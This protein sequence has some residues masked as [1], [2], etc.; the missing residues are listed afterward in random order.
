MQNVPVI[1][2]DYIAK[3]I[4]DALF[5]DAM[6]P[7]GLVAGSGNVKSD[8][9]PIDGYLMSTT[10]TINAMDRNGRLYEITVREV[11]R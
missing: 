6:S 1:Y 10:K 9:H 4:D 2:C 11:T 7:D 3:V 5:R 8:L